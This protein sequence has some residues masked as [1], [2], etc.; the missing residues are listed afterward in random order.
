TQRQR[1]A[2]D[3]IDGDAADG[4]AAPGPA[5]AVPWHRFPKGSFSGDFLHA[6]LEW[7]AAE[8]FALD[9]DPALEARL[10]RRCEGAGRGAYGGDVIAWMRARPARP[11]PSLGAALGE[12][13]VLRPELEFWLPAGALRARELDALCRA[14]LLAG[15]ARP[16]LPARVLHGMLMGFA[17]LV[18]EH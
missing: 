17:D 15:R 16:E 6:Q 8:G 11:L 9:G 4:P 1:A 7:L 18:F 10:R 14:H 13:P 5:A 3:E 2:E 12:L